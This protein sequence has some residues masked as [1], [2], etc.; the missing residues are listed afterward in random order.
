MGNVAFDKKEAFVIARKFDTEY[1][2]KFVVK[3]QVQ[4]VGRSRG[5]FKENGFMSGIHKVQTIEEV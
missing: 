1:K 2:R 5:F 4:A 3:A